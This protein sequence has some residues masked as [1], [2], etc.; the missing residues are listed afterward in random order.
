[1]K[2]LFLSLAVIAALFLGGCGS[3]STKNL[4]P[5]SAKQLLQAQLTTES[6]VTGVTSTYA[7]LVPL[8][9]HET[10]VD[11]ELSGF[12]GNNVPAILGRLVKAGL[13]KK[14]V[15]SHSY[16]NVTGRYEG[17]AKYDVFRPIVLEM[18]PSGMITGSYRYFNNGYW[19]DGVIFGHITPDGSLDLQG[20]HVGPY[21]C[22]SPSDGLHAWRVQSGGTG[23]G[24]SL[25][26][27][28]TVHGPGSPGSFALTTYT[29]NLT[30]KFGNLLV[31]TPA[32]RLVK[33]GDRAQVDSVDELLL[34]EMGETI[35]EGK[36]TWHLVYNEAGAAIFA[37]DGENG[38]GRAVFRKQPDGAWICKS[39]EFTGATPGLAKP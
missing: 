23:G 36:F 19:C 11:Y 31:N 27:P 7:S 33:V 34:G 26:G 21:Y 25:I 22:P 35:A 8:L 6:K 20:Q 4:T 16:A 2:T 9:D 30:T 15:G 1:M 3:A 12:V 24:L 29:Y 17:D 37:T 32:G 39:H 13:V 18:K 14:T 38:T 10:F 28:L 5:S